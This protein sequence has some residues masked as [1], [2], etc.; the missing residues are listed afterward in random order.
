[1]WFF[2]CVAFSILLT[3]S[4]VVGLINSGI[5]ILLF[6][7]NR[8]CIR[9]VFL[10]I[11]PF[12]FLIPVMSVFYI[13]F[14]FWFTNETLVSTLFVAGKAI[15]TLLLLIMVMSLYLERNSSRDILT[16]FRTLWRK[17][18]RPWQGVEDFFLFLGLT[19]RFYP[20]FQ[21]EWEATQRAQQALGLHQNMSRFEQIKL[22]V[23]T[24]PG[25]V[26]YNYRKADEM[27]VVMKLRGFGQIVPRGVAFPVNFSFTDALLMVIIPGIIF[28]V[29]FLAAV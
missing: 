13:G 29:R 19:L 15:V 18:D 16:A 23:R 17:M 5:I 11:R 26:L 22:L 25:I 12:L 8:R 27:A 28:G 14:S 3:N 2:L 6:I 10:R 9:N 20:T 24:L 7:I 21:R 1:M 4:F